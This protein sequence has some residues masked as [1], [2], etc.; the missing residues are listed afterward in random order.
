M[1]LSGYGWERYI[2][3]DG[4]MVCM[5]GFGASGPA[6]QLFEKFGFTAENVAA[7]VRSL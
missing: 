7:T 1:A 3:L 5:T 2:G 6:A 4:K